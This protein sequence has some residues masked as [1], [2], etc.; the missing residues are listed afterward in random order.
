M[1]FKKD[2]GPTKIKIAIV[3]SHCVGKSELWKRLYAYFYEKGINIGLLGEIARKC[4][5]P[6]NE[7]TTIRAQ[8]WILKEQKKEEAELM[9][10]YDVLLTDRGTIDNFAYGLR[11]A[12]KNSLDENLINEMER[13]V[14]EHSKSYSA[15][16]FIQPFDAKKL[17][18]DKIRS[19]DPKWRKEMHEEID[20]IIKRFKDSYSTPVFSLTGNEEELFEQAKNI[21][22]NDLQLSLVK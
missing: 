8:N 15:L 13:E 21:L 7:D 17:K 2:V 19:V 22:E 14:F 4:P 18:S 3:G 12:V 9:K 16:L 6:I 1:T 11:V 10:A 20:K 5:Y